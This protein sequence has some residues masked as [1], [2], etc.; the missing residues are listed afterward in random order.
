MLMRTRTL[1]FAP[2]CAALLLSACNRSAEPVEQ[3]EAEAAPATTEVTEVAVERPPTIDEDILTDAPATEADNTIP[4]PF[5][6]TFDESPASCRDAS[7]ERM[8]VS[9]DSVRIGEATGKVELVRVVGDNEITLRLG[10][11]RSGESWQAAERYALSADGNELYDR[12]QEPAFT[13][14]RCR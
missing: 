4:Q 10:M 12:G 8:V 13:R 3:V 9:A 11:S 1:V 6:G 14:V 7:E 2:L 5:H